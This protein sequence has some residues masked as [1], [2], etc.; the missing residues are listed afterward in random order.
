MC[1]FLLVPSEEY[2]ESKI[3]V[4]SIHQTDESAEVVF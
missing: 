4:T 1:R 2:V 3:F